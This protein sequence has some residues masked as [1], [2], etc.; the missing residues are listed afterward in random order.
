[1]SD[2]YDQQAKI[3]GTI[4]NDE[5]GEAATLN[6]FA[7]VARYSKTAADGAASTATSNTKIFTN[8]FT[9]PLKI[10]RA[11]AQGNGA[12][13]TADNTN[14]ATISLLTDDGAGGAPAA[15]MTI[16]TQLT[17]QGT[18]TS[19]VSVAFANPTAAALTVPAGGNIW[20][21]ISKTGTG[22]VVPISDY[23]I[24]LAKL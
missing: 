22:V 12:G 10:V 5:G 14:Y 17:A 1:M 11:T 15:A 18:W 2:L 4:G 23:Q 24:V 6:L 13:L 3:A 9:T 20:F 19:N 21:A 7:L 16:I 8:P